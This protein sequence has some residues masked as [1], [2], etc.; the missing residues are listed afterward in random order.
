L[1]TASTGATT[2]TTTVPGNNTYPK[3]QVIKL[4]S[5]TGNELNMLEFQVVSGGLNVAQG[6]TASQSS[7]YGNKYA[8]NAV[9][10]STSTFSH[11]NDRGFSWWMVDLGQP[12]DIESINIV[13]R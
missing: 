12:F 6:K 8:S 2:S 4:N 5:I 3:A 10:G 1:Q 7:T 11:T 13:N 9:D